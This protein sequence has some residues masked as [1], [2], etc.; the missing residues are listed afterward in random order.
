[1]ERVAIHLDDGRKERN[2]RGLFAAT[3]MERLP[4]LPVEEEGDSKTRSSA[5]TSSSA[6]SPTVGSSDCSRGVGQPL[7]SSRFH[8]REK[9]LLLAHDR[10]AY[11]ALG[12]LVA[13]VGTTS[14]V[15]VAQGYAELH[16]SA[17]EDRHARR[18]ANVLTHGGIP[19]ERR[20]R[21]ESP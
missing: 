8:S 16:E 12:R 6:C 15:E 11:A 17:P 21:R 14:R 2:G 13:R 4:L 18:H 1:M 5:R 9:M 19:E 20:R 10:S 3:L 7:T